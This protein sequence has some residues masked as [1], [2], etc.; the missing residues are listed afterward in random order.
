[1]HSKVSWKRA[2]LFLGNGPP[3]GAFSG[4]PKARGWLALRGRALIRAA[5]V[6]EQ[7]LPAAHGRSPE[8]PFPPPP[9][10]GVY[11]DKYDAQGPWFL[12]SAHPPDE[13]LSRLKSRSGRPHECNNK[14]NS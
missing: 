3:D 6:R 11:S 12:S 14:T 7:D 10:R 4:F 8:R 5:T 1:M 9:F 2:K 13:W